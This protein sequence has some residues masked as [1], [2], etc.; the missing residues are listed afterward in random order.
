MRRGSFRYPC[1]VLAIVFFLAI[2]LMKIPSANA[3]YY[4]VSGSGTWSTMSSSSYSGYLYPGYT[5]GGSTA[6]LSTGWNFSFYLPGNLALSNGT[7][8]AT[9]TS[10]N[11]SST[12][13]TSYQ[14]TD[15][16]FNGTGTGITLNET[17]GTEKIPGGTSTSHIQQFM[18]ENREDFPSDFCL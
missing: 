5:N 18:N 14:A 16:L 15:F 10:F 4:E 12:G 6:G 11:F 8:S 9:S 2:F 7:N 13:L 3:T 1:S 17:S